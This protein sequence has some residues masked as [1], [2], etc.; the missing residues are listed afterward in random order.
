MFL[1]DWLKK[2]H[3]NQLTEAA[4]QQVKIYQ[5]LYGFD[6]LTLGE[7]ILQSFDFTTEE[8]SLKELQ[9]I[10]LLRQQQQ[11]VS[12][13]SSNT[14]DTDQPAET[15]VPVNQTLPSAAQQLIQVARQTPPMR[16][17]EAIKRK[18]RICF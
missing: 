5:Q 1:T 9:R 13:K 6:E 14:P 16:Y 18:R 4:L 17:L 15:S 7:L 3:I 12:R 11:N 10:V 8:V 2:Q